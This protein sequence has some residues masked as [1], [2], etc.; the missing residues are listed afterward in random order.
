MI[1]KFDEFNNKKKIL[2]IQKK[3]LKKKLGTIKKQQMAN[4]IDKYDKQKQEIQKKMNMYVAG[5]SNYE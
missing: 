2:N 5:S 3:D 1:D 4:K